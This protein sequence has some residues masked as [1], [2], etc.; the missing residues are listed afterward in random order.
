LEVGK[1]LLGGMMNS[2]T[3]KHAN[4]FSVFAGF[5]ITKRDKDQLL[6]IILLIVVFAMPLLFS[7]IGGVISQ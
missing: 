4:I 2:L 7:A 5:S 6:L 1:Q 3:A